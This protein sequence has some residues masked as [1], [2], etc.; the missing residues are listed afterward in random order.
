MLS[1][2]TLIFSLGLLAPLLPSVHAHGQVSGVMANGQYN[3]GPNVR[4]F[5]LLDRGSS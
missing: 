5:C 3:A 2:A 4:F 1:T